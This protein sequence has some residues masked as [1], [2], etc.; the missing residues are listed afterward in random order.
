MC[1]LTGGHFCDPETVWA[2]QSFSIGRLHAK[3]FL[4]MVGR[5]V[6]SA[7]PR[8]EATPTRMSA[9][10]RLAIRR[11]IA[12]LR[13]KPHPMSPR[14]RAPR[15][16][17]ITGHAKSAW[18]GVSPAPQAAFRGSVPGRLA[19]QYFPPPGR[20]SRS[21][22][23]SRSTLS[24]MTFSASFLPPSNEPIEHLVQPTHIDTDLARHL[25]LI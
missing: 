3:I 17:H 5:L 6:G 9:T 24:A 23:C 22:A 8:V 21:S 25:Q 7:S 1:K 14:H 10:R 12:G 19:R 2:N 15:R 13:Q 4:P 16:K 18:G 20:L 11:F